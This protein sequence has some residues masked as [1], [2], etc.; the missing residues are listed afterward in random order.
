MSGG[1]NSILTKVP[2]SIASAMLLP[3]ISAAVSILGGE[4]AFVFMWL[5]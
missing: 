1:P 5:V 2:G 4:R 3:D